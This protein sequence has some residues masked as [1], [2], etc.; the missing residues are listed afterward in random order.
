[1]EPVV[2]TGRGRVRG[3]VSGGVAAFKGI[4]YA[5]APV[6]DLR[7]AAPAPVPAWDGVREATQYGPTAPKPP[8]RSPL[9]QLLP[10]PVIPGEDFLNLNVWTPDFAAS[11]PV[12]VW[13]HGGAFVHGSSAVS[14]YDG[15]NFARDGLVFVSI[16]YRLG[17]PGFALLEDAPANRGLLDQ[18]AALQWVRDNIAAFGGNP[19]LVTIAGESAGAM[20]VLTLLAM[21]AAEGLFRRAIAQSGAGHAVM[22]ADTARRVAAALA[23]S[24]EVEPSRAGFASVTPEELVGAQEALVERIRADPNPETWGESAADS[25]AFAPCIDGEVLTARPI[26]RIADG[27]SADVDVLIG[28]NTDEFTLFFVPFGVDG[29]IDDNLLR[30]MIGVHGLDVDAALVAYRA[31][32]PDATPGQLLMDVLRDRMFRIPALRVAEA[33][34]ALDIPTYVYRFDWPTTEYDGRLGATHALEIGFVFD[35]L[36]VRESSALAGPK[37]PQ[38]LAERMHQ[39]W[40]AFAS[41]GRPGWSRYGDNRTEMTFGLD[42]GTTDDP[43]AELRALWDG[44]R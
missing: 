30:M 6:G 14:L 38:E 9:D 41:T 7:F 12:L 5:A 36:R 37:P 15:S 31:A 18:V 43:D 8:Y 11:L 4:P 23:E 44:I 33:R 29:A 20:S 10:D 42:S 24:L 16:N 1:M 2:Q 13:I 22:A 34:W 17:A 28:T 26:D 21:P 3:V 39:A 32:R 40:V 27:A 19:D 25:R 35:N